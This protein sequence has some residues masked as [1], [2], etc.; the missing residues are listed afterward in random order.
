MRPVKGRDE[1]QFRESRTKRIIWRSTKP[2]GTPSQ[3]A[4]LVVHYLIRCLL[5]CALLIL[6]KLGLHAT[7]HGDVAIIDQRKIADDCVSPNHDDDKHIALL[8]QGVLGL[9]R[10]H[11][12][13]PLDVLRETAGGGEAVSGRL[14][15]YG[16]YYVIGF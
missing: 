15:R 11:A 10:D 6:T 9:T 1:A 5:T 8:S 12:T 7:A 3:P 14:D 2:C 16:Q 4:G 13:A